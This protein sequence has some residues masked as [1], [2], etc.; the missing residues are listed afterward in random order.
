MNSLINLTDL[1]AA[2]INTIWQ[3]VEGS[4]STGTLPARVAWSFEGNGIR[5]RTSFVQ[6]FQDL[7][8]AYVELP[9]LLKTDEAVSDLA[10][11]LD[12]YYDLYV[13]RDSHH[14]RL[15]EFAEASRRPVINAMSSLSHPCEVLTDAFYLQQTF[16]DIRKV[17]ILLW[18]PL[19]N[20][21]RTWYE[22]A[23]VFDFKITHFCPLKYREDN[24]QVVY[25][26]TPEGDF[27][28]V[29]TDGWPPD[30]NDSM[31]TLT[32]DHFPQIGNAVYL[33]VPPVTV[34]KE[35]AFDLNNNDFFIGYKQK[36]L[37]LPVQKEIIKFV[38]T[39]EG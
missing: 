2:Q 1:N 5:T 4:D 20:V 16:D 29:I 21:L 19:T 35:V 27:D 17:N 10:G 23:E 12:D 28:I 11:Y 18:G 39:P 30:F 34:G 22:I 9:N 37:L 32:N 6:A 24:A 33:P 13:I 3:R 26:D 8:Q 7:G 31:Y 36:S 25:I 15:R 14:E 38:L